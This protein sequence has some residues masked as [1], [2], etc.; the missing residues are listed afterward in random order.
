MDAN[1]FPGYRIAK[2]IGEDTFLVERR[3]GNIVR[4]NKRHIK[5][6]IY[7]SEYGGIVPR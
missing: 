6:A 3:N 1:W 7:F 2:R 4:L 5:M